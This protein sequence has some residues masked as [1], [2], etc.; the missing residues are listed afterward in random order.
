MPNWTQWCKGSRLVNLPWARFMICLLI[1]LV[2]FTSTG[3]SLK[4]W[5]ALTF[6]DCRSIPTTTL[7]NLII[8]RPSPPNANRPT[9]INRPKWLNIRDHSYFDRRFRATLYYSELSLNRDV[10]VKHLPSPE[11]DETARHNH[12]VAIILP[13]YGLDRF[14]M[15]KYAEDLLNH[16][17]IDKALLIDF[18]GQGESNYS[19]I[20]LGPEESDI[21]NDL[22]GYLGT[23]GSAKTKFLIMGYSYGGGVALELG[24]HISKNT[25]GHIAAIVAIAPFVS[26]RQSIR[27]Y[28][29]QIIPNREC[30][31]SLREISHALSLDSKRFSVNIQNA[32][33]FHSLQNDRIQ[34]LVIFGT[35]DAISPMWLD[36]EVAKSNQAAAVGL[37]PE[38]GHAQLLLHHGIVFNDVIYP[39]IMDSVVNRSSRS[40][41]AKPVIARATKPYSSR[42]SIMPFTGQQL[43]YAADTSIE[44]RLVPYAACKLGLMVSGKSLYKTFNMYAKQDLQ[45][46]LHDTNTELEPGEYIGRACTPLRGDDSPSMLFETVVH[47]HHL[48]IKLQP[49]VDLNKIL[50][51]HRLYFNACISTQWIPV[52]VAEPDYSYGSIRVL[53]YIGKRLLS[54]AMATF[55]PYHNCWY[56]EMFCKPH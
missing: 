9:L 45:I 33:P 30:C 6:I 24:S 48:I 3:A 55:H 35:N 51:S 1:G 46:E 20:G 5:G 15:T 14:S 53:V 43:T 41:F 31:P 17:V 29:A 25:S 7:A 11:S 16:Q 44:C 22:I 26:I 54:E 32:D 10:F 50:L 42:R 2:P 39:W 37:L 47:T 49:N 38:F 18:P 4:T 21:L 34:T 8:Q 56:G 40:M 12:I 36:L 19:H 27:N 52:I 28:V 23:R 13:G